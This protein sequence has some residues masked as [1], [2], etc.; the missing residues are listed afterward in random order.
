MSNKLRIRP[1][2]TA[3]SVYAG[4]A[5]AS[6]IVPVCGFIIAGPTLGVRRW[7][8]RNG[9]KLAM[10][11]MGSSL[12]I[13][14]QEH[15]PTGPCVCVSNHASFLDGLVLTAA[16]PPRFSFLVQHGAAS[17]PLV[18]KTI[19]R[20]GVSFV[21]RSSA[22]EAAA[23]TR[24]L[25]RRIKEGESFTIFPEGTFKQEPGLLPF[26]SGAFLIAA[27]AG[28]PVLPAVIRGSRQVLSQN[29]KLPQYGHVEIEF[30]PAIAPE[31]EGK[32]AVR[33]LSEA[34][35]QVILAHVGEPDAAPPE[36]HAKT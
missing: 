36:T 24:E 15:I 18:G 16:L 31:G 13:K 14:G 10:R 29:D 34:A 19:S 32:Q 3:Y 21:N 27:R 8:G 17:W 22:R 5:F 20:M 25:L 6:V 9:V 23:A 4:A 7:V 2:K 11:A 30:F 28:V 35:R 33:A 12:T 1:L 26:N